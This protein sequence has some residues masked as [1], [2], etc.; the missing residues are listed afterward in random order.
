MPQTK[1]FAAYS[2]AEPLRPY[3]FDRREPDANDVLIE[4]HYCGVCHSDLHTVRG[5]WGPQKYPLAPGHEIVGK[6]VKAGK[7]VTRFKVG[8]NVGVGCMVN[9]CSKCKSC[10]EG[11]EQFCE[12][13]ATFTYGAADPKEKGAVTQGGYSSLI[14]VDA[15]FVLS[16][17]KNMPLDQAAPLLCA[18][19]TT[20]SPL[21]RWKIKKGQSVGVAGLGGLGHMAVKFARSMGAKVTVLSTSEKKR[22]DA[23]KL[24]A[25]KF[26]V[27][28]TPEDFAALAGTFD[29][30]LDTISADHDYNAYLG[31]LKKGGTLTLVGVPNPQP[32]ASGSL[33]FGRK[34]LNGSLIGGI[35]ETQ[36]M[37]N[38]CGKHK[39]VSDI[40]LIP[41]QKIN[42]A[43]DRMLKS[44][45][46]YRFV[47]DMKTL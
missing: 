42:T 9:S 15:K 46:K 31:L 12:K 28:K 7:K 30:I 29:F 16:M 24:G 8:Q 22:G 13:G 33:I 21:K 1:S 38:Y 18:G 19:I 2:A 25:H 20:Y 26:A 14:T 17:P 39:I 40:E 23:L 32:L 47:I 37:L 4:I 41:M 5:D 10:K 6:V 35:K 44:D 45:V 27:T 36:E 3:T 43:Y 11:E 34:I